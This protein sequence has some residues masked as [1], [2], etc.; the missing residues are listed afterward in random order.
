MDLSQLWGNIKGRSLKNCKL[1]TIFMNMDKK[2]LLRG[3]ISILAI[4]WAIVGLGFGWLE[5]QA[6]IPIIVAAVSGLFGEK[7]YLKASK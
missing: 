5:G 4:V 7:D 2:T 3:G 1:K 6:A